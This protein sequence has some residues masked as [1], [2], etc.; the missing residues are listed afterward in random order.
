[1]VEQLLRVLYTGDLS[2]VITMPL[3]GSKLPYLHSSSFSQWTFL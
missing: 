1:M 3:V 2:L